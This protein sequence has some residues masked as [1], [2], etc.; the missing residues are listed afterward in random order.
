MKT[1]L[2]LKKRIQEKE[3]KQDTFAITLVHFKAALLWVGDGISL[4]LIED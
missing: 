1:L 4:S 3:R 2:E